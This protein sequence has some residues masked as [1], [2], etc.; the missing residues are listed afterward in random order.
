M[1][2]SALVPAMLR[3]DPVFVAATVNALPAGRDVLSSAISKVTVSA[4][5]FTDALAIR[6]GSTVTV[7]VSASLKSVPFLTVSENVKSVWLCTDGAMNT[8]FAAVASSS[9]TLGPAVCVQA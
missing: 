9:A 4:D 8:G 5:P 3:L 2:T 7:T 6:D 1:E